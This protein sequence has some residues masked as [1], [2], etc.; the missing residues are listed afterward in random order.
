MKKNHE[1]LSQVPRRKR[2]PAEV[3]AA[4]SAEIQAEIGS[5][6]VRMMGNGRHDQNDVPADDDL[7][8]EE[9]D[10]IVG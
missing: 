5:A 4:A 9:Q 6:K 1:P 2:P 10:E 8:D 3:P 7:P